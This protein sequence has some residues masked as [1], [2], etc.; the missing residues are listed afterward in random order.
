MP[1]GVLPFKYEA[2][3]TSAGMTA[4]A[5]LPVYLDLALVAGLGESIA[6]HLAV[7]SGGQGWLD[8][9]MILS[10]VLLNLAGGDCVDD[11]EVLNAD[12]GFARVLLQ[13]E[14]RLLGLPRRKRRELERRWRKERKR[15]VPSPSAAR[16]Y[17]AEFH[18]IVEEAKRAAGPK[19]FIP[20]PNEHLQGLVRINADLLAF[21]QSRSPQRTATLDQDA[22]LV[23]S[24]KREALFCY[25]KFRSYQPLNTW[26]AEQ[27]LVVH[28]EFRDGNVLA[29]HQQLRVLREALD[30]L[31]AGVEEVLLRSDTAGY[32][33][34]LLKYCAEGKD[35]RFGVIEFAVGVDVTKEFKKATAGVAREDWHK[36]YKMVNGK[37]KETGQ[38]YAEVCFVPNEVARTKDGPE[39]RF[40]AIRELLAQPDLPGMEQQDLPFQTMDFGGGRCKL[41]GVVTNRDLPG[42]ELIRWHRERCGKSEEVH[43]VM[44][45]DLAGG[46]LPSGLFGA[47]AAWWQIMILAHNLNAAMKRLVLPEGWVAKRMKAVRYSLI[48]LPGR[49]VRRAR[50]L[51]VRLADGHP[52]TDLLL[53]M[54][55]MIKELAYGPS[56]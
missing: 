53:A 21:I 50:T 13:A 15:A 5:G 48:N 23:E 2:E 8:S 51:F 26:W 10:L 35:K 41:F 28:S 9:Q 20:A 30:C 31:P 25:K 56:G 27:G 49:V 46:K 52:S 36:L 24:H 54:R 29:G 45:D 6:R 17:L 55:S 37:P 4:M 38:E 19:A 34:E 42:D 22:T 1:Q 14:L 3:T 43:A 33:W 7:R 47:N 16:R 44:K 12:D 18:D 32:Q 39:Y 40:L 11:L